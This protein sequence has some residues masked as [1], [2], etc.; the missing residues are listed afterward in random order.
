MKGIPQGELYISI[1]VPVYNAE[2]YLSECL[3]SLLQ[4]TQTAYEIICVD[5]GSTDGSPD[6][7][8]R[9]AAE[10]TCVRV[11]RKE[12]G[13]VSSARN[14]G[15]KIARGEYI[16]FVDSDDAIAY[17]C[18]DQII[19]LLKKYNP[20]C[21][22]IVYQTANVAGGGQLDYIV[23]DAARSVHGAYQALVRRALLMEYRIFFN[24][25]LK[26]G[27]DVLFWYY[28]YLYSQ[29]KNRVTIKTPV[30]FYRRHSNSAMAH[31]TRGSYNKHVSDLIELGR[32]YKRNYDQKISNDQQKLWNT[33]QR[34][35]LSILGAL[36]ILPKSDL[37]YER[38]MAQLRKE[39]LYPIPPLF[40][41][42]AEEKGWK[43]KVTE[44]VKLGFSLELL[45]KIYYSIAKRRS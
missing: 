8:D 32:I 38:V 27:E 39:G 5:D 37:D 43:G 3:D 14:A 6:I 44:T 35:Y 9:Y 40:W 28:V 31:P 41:K 15:L 33:K 4:Q 2:R 19:P 12:N 24:E 20:E 30:Y 13:G 29:G 10:H 42:V 7:L 11:L 36:T 34:W 21:M 23:E 45:Y 17:G 18:L 16:W 26:Y 25:T 1:I 22:E